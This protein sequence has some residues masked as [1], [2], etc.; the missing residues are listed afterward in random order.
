MRFGQSERLETGRD[1][2]EALESPW[3][4]GWGSGPLSA[5]P[6]CFGRVVTWQG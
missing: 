3:V 5:G 2:G 1:G 6:L 4:L